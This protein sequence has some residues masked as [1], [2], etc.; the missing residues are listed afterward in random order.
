MEK[1]V[2][3]EQ[4]IEVDYDKELVE[5]IVKPQ[6]INSQLDSEVHFA[7]LKQDEDVR[8]LI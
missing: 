6:F 3:Q 7:D 5:E 1:K 8:S 4:V 2:I